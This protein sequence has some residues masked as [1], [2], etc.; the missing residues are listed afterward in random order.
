[1]PRTFTNS[2]NILPAATHLQAEFPIVTAVQN[3]NGYNTFELIINSTAR[4]GGTS[5]TASIEEWDPAAQDWESTAL[6]TGAAISTADTRQIL[7]VGP[8]VTAAA[9]AAERR[10]APKR[11]RVRV[12]ETGTITSAAFSIGV[13][14]TDA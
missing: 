13:T 14:Y 6:L 11:W 7:K 1:M 9:N 8:N 12:I 4:T 5:I 10:I 3:S 2:K